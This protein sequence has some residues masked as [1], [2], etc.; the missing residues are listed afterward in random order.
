MSRPV[1]PAHLRSRGD[2]ALQHG[3]LV[4]QQQDLSG[5]PRLG[6]A[7]QAQSPEQS[8]HAQIDQTQTYSPGSSEGG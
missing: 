5:L 2:M 1:S 4:A 3:E 6:T 7:R 8:A